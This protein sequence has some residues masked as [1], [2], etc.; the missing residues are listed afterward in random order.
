MAV[1]EGL[2]ARVRERLAGPT[3]SERRMFGGAVLMTHGHMTVGVT[4]AELM[5]R[6]GRDAVDDALTRPGTRPLD[7]S[8]RPMRDWVLIDGSALD[9]DELDAWVSRASTFVATLPPRT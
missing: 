7:M 4:G 8:G 9:D 5:V 2:V 3:L 6:V 1:D